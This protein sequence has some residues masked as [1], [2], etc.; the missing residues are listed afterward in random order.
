MK[1]QNKPN[2]NNNI[3][4]MEDTRLITEEKKVANTLNT[5]FIDKVEKLKNG[6]FLTCLLKINFNIIFRYLLLTANEIKK[7]SPGLFFKYFI[8]K[9]TL[10]EH[11][12]T[13]YL[14]SVKIHFLK[15]QLIL[16]ADFYRNIKMIFVVLLLDM[17]K[18]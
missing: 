4:L 17:K 7:K 6:I 3:T 15:K 10:L 2:S 8:S 16:Y 14:R 13:T 1:N 18:K 5:H 11:R 9:Q 12:V